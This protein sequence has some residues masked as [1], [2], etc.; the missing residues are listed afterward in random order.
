MN[1]TLSIIVPVY[2]VEKYLKK[3]IDSILIQPFSNFELILVN[4][5]S[6]DDSLTICKEYERK[7]TRIVIV[8]K[9]N[10]GLSSARNSGLEVAKGNYVS[11]IDSDDF[12]SYDFYESNMIFLEENSSIDMLILPYCEYS[13]INNSC[14]KNK[15][16][17]I[18]GKINVANYLFSK[19]YNCAVWRCIYK[20]DIFSNL[21]FADGRLFEDGYIL[22]EIANR[23]L[24]L[25]IS[26]IGC[27]YYVV[28]EGSICNSNYSLKKRTQQ[29]DTLKKILDYCIETQ[30]EKKIFVHY[31]LSYSYL[32]GKAIAQNS[33]NTLRSYV[34]DWKNKYRLLY[35]SLLTSSIKYKFIML[36]ITFCGFRVAAKF[37]DKK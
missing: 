19:E 16:L 8:D 30:L 21:R 13:E 14:Y 36:L 22:P 5:G 35:Q 1:L 4:D 25:A 32:I 29:L 28:R 7:D 31:Y 10:G 2:N 23:V 12:I 6:T 11:F 20:T 37:I 33:Y 3:C 26:E 9:P 34:N 24:S 18:Y 17:I 27:Y 15:S